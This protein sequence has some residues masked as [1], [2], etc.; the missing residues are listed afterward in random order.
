MASVTTENV[1]ESIPATGTA[2]A[3]FRSTST[4]HARSAGTG[5][6]HT[7]RGLAAFNK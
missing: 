4:G 5:A 1:R 2:S 3:V 6:N 7:Q